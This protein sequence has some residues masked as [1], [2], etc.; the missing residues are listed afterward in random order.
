MDPGEFRLQRF[1]KLKDDLGPDA[2]LIFSVD[3]SSQN[4]TSMEVSEANRG[5][6]ELNRRFRDSVYFFNDKEMISKFKG[7]E[8]MPAFEDMGKSLAWAY[9]FEGFSVLLDHYKQR[10][11]KTYDEYCGIWFVED[12]LGFSGDWKEIMDVNMPEDDWKKADFYSINSLRQINK[13]G[14]ETVRFYNQARNEAFINKFDDESLW[15][16][17]SYLMYFSRD[18]FAKCEENA[19]EG[20][21]AWSEM[22]VAT[23]A[24]N[25][26]LRDEYGNERDFLV[27]Q[28]NGGFKDT[29]GYFAFPQRFKH[30]QEE[31]QQHYEEYLVAGKSRLMHPMKN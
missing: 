12:D 13:T 6:Q 3:I 11:G 15:A 29:E 8:D 22:F 24:H 19:M 21:H 17:D 28:I 23:V 1:Q 25:D 7:L 30:T 26:K 14:L 2:T 18:F 20:R 5:I 16:D 31:I 10:T 4:T 27:K 9:H